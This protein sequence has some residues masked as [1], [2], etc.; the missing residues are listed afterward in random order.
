MCI[1]RNSFNENNGFLYDDNGG[2]FSGEIKRKLFNYTTYIPYVNGKKEGVSGFL[3]D[4][5]GNKKIMTNMR[6]YN[7]LLD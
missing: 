2:L 7:R 3:Y 4:E 1:W 6:L 5:Q